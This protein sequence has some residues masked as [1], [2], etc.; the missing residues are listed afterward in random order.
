VCVRAVCM[1]TMQIFKTFM[2]LFFFNLFVNINVIQR[3]SDAVK[4]LP[5]S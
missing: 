1:S 4:S 3:R 2:F 5:N